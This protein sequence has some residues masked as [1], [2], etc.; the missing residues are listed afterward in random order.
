MRREENQGG[1]HPIGPRQ[2]DQAV[3]EC[4]EVIDQPSLGL[5]LSRIDLDPMRPRDGVA[6]S[7]R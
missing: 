4:T 6:I 5:D 3:I 1:P 7:K 2:C